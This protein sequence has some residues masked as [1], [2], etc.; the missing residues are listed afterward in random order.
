M[1]A[2]LK[3]LVGGRATKVRTSAAGFRPAL[4]A[5]ESRDLMSVAGYSAVGQKDFFIDAV[6]NIRERDQYGHFSTLG[7]SAAQVSVLQGTSHA[8]ARADVLKLDG[9][10]WQWDDVGGW[11]EIKA[12]GVKQVSA[13]WNGN[14]AVLFTNGNL[15]LYN[16]D[17]NVWTSLR[18]N[19]VSASIGLDLW[20]APMVDLVTTGG[21]AYEVRTP[22]GVVT[23]EYLGSGVTQISAGVGSNSAILG[24][25]GNVFD[26]T[27]SNY[28]A[29]TGAFT[30]AGN[31]TFLRSGVASVSCGTDVQGV[32]MIDVV[33]TNGWAM[34]WDGSTLNWT[35]LDYGMQEADAGQGGVT[36]LYYG[37]GYITRYIDNGPGSPFTVT[38]IDGGVG[39]NGLG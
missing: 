19:V 34:E 20:N 23:A 38:T 27:D 1:F 37:P 35:N 2:I 13:G 6:N 24:S 36:Y 30:G 33:T 12:G 17:T 22:G 3:K 15:S 39:R 14:S 11:T 8:S 7:N 21:D 5:L 18:T 9:S 16:T 31:S 32:I 25:N 4:E 29:Y 26:H 10:F 28:A